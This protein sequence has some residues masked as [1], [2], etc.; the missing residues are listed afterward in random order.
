MNKYMRIVTIILLLSFAAL[1]LA[2]CGGGG[3]TGTWKSVKLETA[4]VV[5]DAEEQGLNEV[6]E[7]KSD[8]TGKWTTSDGVEQEMTWKETDDGVTLSVDMFG[9]Q[10]DFKGKLE[11]GQLIVDYAGLGDVYFEK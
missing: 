3:Y 11:D 7:I 6:V 1:S 10:M 8:G 5:M 2:A 9:V 4:G